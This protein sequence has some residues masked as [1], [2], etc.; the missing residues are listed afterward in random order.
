MQS[1]DKNILQEYIIEN[2]IL[3]KYF[4]YLQTKAYCK[5]L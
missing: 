5:Q 1:K 3:R 4:I 2:T